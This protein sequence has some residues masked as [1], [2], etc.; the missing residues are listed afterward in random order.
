MQPVLAH[1]NYKK[2][3]MQFYIMITKNTKSHNCWK[4]L[5]NFPTTSPSSF[6][7]VNTFL[8]IL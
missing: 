5:I 3:R 6:F 1:C 2:E 8:S 7:F 4:E